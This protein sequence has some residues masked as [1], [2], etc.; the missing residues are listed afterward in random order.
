MARRLKPV[1]L[2]PKIDSGHLQ[3]IRQAAGWGVAIRPNQS[4]RVAP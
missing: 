4:W 2:Y 3:V 1:Q